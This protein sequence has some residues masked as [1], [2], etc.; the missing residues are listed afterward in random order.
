MLCVN[1][2]S[3]ACYAEGSVTHSC[4]WQWGI[5]LFHSCI[6]SGAHPSMSER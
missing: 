1:A 4:L 5:G 2:L 3:H 6:H